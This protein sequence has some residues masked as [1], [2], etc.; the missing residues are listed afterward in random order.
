MASAYALLCIDVNNRIG[1]RLSI[2]SIVLDSLRPLVIPA[3]EQ[4]QITCALK[5]AHNVS[6][7]LA[8][9]AQ[10]INRVIR[11]ANIDAPLS[12]AANDAAGTQG[13]HAAAAVCT[14][15][16]HGNDTIRVRSDF[17]EHGVQRYLL[18]NTATT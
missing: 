1:F 2:A 12:L 11:A 14:Y 9:G 17:S 16:K 3:R 15:S 4:L 7:V 5:A 10:R 13:F 18:L 6:R 8:V